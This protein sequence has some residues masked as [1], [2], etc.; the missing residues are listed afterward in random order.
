[1]ATAYHRA[2]LDAP[3]EHVWAVVRD[4]AAIDRWQP[5]VRTSVGEGREPRIGDTAPDHARRRRRP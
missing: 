5:L 1:M 2:E 3:A 4:F